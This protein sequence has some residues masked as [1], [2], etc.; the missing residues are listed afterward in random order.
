MIELRR[1]PERD[2][3]HIGVTI[4]GAAGHAVAVELDGRSGKPGSFERFSQLSSA[5][6]VLPAGAPDEVSVWAHRVSPDGRSTEVPATVVVAGHHIS[7]APQ[8]GG[9]P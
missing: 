8:P 7:I 4:A 6:V 2:L 3:G 1:E 9:P 5:S